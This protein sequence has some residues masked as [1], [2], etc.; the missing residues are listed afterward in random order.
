[1]CFNRE[2]PEK[3]KIKPNIVNAHGLIPVSRLPK[4]PRIPKT[5]NIAPATSAMTPISLII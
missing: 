1:M 3:K 2:I 4:I 5:S